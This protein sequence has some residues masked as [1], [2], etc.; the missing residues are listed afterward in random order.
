MKKLIL[1]IL[2]IALSLTQLSVLNAMA[3]KTEEKSNKVG[4]NFYSSK[5]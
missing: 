3:S 1:I 4:G 5:G 2:I